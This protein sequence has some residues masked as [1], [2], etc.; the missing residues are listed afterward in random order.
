[1]EGGRAKI[2]NAARFRKHRDG[3]YIVY[4][5]IDDPDA[6]MKIQNEDENDDAGDEPTMDEI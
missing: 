1:M 4:L 3:I 5:P 2:N 6:Y